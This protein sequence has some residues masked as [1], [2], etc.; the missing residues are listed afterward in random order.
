MVDVGH[1]GRWS[2]F[3]VN[4]LHVMTAITRNTRPFVA[5]LLIVQLCHTQPSPVLPLD[6][7]GTKN[8]YNNTYCAHDDDASQ[9][10]IETE[11]CCPPAQVGS[12]DC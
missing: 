6:R 7:F 5:A 8:T 11:F 4:C 1:V 2:Q 9:N 10:V 12:V 3:V